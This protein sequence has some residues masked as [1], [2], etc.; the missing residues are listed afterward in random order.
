MSH[1]LEIKY[2]AFLS[3]SHR[4][5]RVAR[6]L[7]R[8][9]EAFTIDRD[10]VGR[11][12]DVGPIPKTL[13]PIFRDRHDFSAGYNLIE[14]TKPALQ[15]SQFLIVLCSPAA[16]QSAA[17][18]E[19][20][21][22]FKHMVAGTE[23]DDAIIPVIIDGKP[24]DPARECF[25]PALKFELDAAGTVTDR[26]EALLAADIREEGDGWNL[27]EAKIAA[28]LLGLGTDEVFRRADRHRRQRERV[29]NVVI[30]ALALLSITASA[31]GWWAYTALQR[32]EATLNSVLSIAATEREASVARAT[33][34]GL[35]RTNILEDLQGVQTLVGELE[36][37]KRVTP[38]LKH[39]RARLGIELARIHGLQG[40]T[41]R[42]RI[43]AELAHELMQ[44]VVQER[45]EDLHFQRELSITHIELGELAEKDREFDLAREH[46]LA[47]RAIRKELV[48][49]APDNLWWRRDLS[50]ILSHLGL[51]SKREGDF[52]TAMRDFGASLVLREGLVTAQEGNPEKHFQAR[53]DLGVILER[54]GEL[55]L[56]NGEPERALPH[57][58]RGVGLRRGL[59][60]DQPESI[61]ALDDLGVAY[62][63][64][65]EAQLALAKKQDRPEQ[66]R[67][68]A[69]Q[70]WREA[71]SLFQRVVAEDPSNV[72]RRRNLAVAERALGVHAARNRNWIAAETH[73]TAAR[74]LR[75][76]LAEAERHNPQ[77]RKDLAHSE[78][79]LADALMGAGE[80]SKAI[81]A[82][83]AAIEL[84]QV[85]EAEKELLL[86]ESRMLRDLKR[87]VL[88]YKS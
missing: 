59:L 69:H 33:K 55:V 5:S 23:R 57:F 79:L 24:D 34:L 19:E 51:L 86:K 35:A 47:S 84:L 39:Q 22:L 36:R 41:Q 37:L 60:K 25:P 74:E 1:V 42:Q 7:H 11:T 52:G 2:R 70:D 15:A 62:T 8:G 67:E 58:E 81:D 46:Y 12:T 73:L 13:R 83:E 43:Q 50:V 56:D 78:K 20:I 45:P 26:P 30:T 88:R 61:L 28:R 71:H 76:W 14:A 32:V 38:E 72:D 31:S 63:K 65:A 6:K 44:E 54:L 75:A 80:T 18:N 66:R 3:Y 68:A 21:R 4:D 49:A 10:L 85:L 48:E 16:A 53:R 77:R 82:Y 29:R 87:K 9:L 64:R 17:V 27:A 40:D